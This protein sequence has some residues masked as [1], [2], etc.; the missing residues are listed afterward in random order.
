ML[1]QVRI[2]KDIH[3]RAKRGYTFKCTR[4]WLHLSNHRKKCSRQSD[5][6]NSISEFSWIQITAN[7]G[8]T[9]TQHSISTFSCLS[10]LR[11]MAFSRSSTFLDINSKSCN[12][13]SKK[14]SWCVI[15]QSN[16]TKEYLVLILRLKSSNRHYE[17]TF[18]RNSCVMTSRS[19]MGSTVSS[20]WMTS[21]SSKAPSRPKS[22]Y[23]IVSCTTQFLL[24]K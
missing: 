12:D 7:Y 18:S 19:R 15:V 10:L 21:G 22:S 11:F 9:F 20:T 24:M 1:W 14:R 17:N 13:N 23:K 4:A 8:H 6:C 5:Y 16:I 2:K 3:F